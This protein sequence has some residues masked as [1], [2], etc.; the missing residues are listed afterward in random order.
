MGSHVVFSREREK[1]GPA[2]LQRGDEGTSP[3]RFALTYPSAAQWAPIPA[4]SQR[5]EDLALSRL[6]GEDSK[7]A[8]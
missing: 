3:H 2:A 7:G 5:S 4:A 8:F 1:K 6:A